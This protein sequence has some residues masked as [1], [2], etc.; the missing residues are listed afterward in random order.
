MTFDLTKEFHPEL[1]KLLE[2]VK[3]TLKM[4]DLKDL[5]FGSYFG[6]DLFNLYFKI[7]KIMSDIYYDI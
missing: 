7:L 3:V 6:I 5:E 4:Q 1:R 2:E